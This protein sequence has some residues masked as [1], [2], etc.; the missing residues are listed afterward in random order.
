MREFE[1]KPVLLSPSSR[2]FPGGL[3]AALPDA[4]TCQITALGNLDILPSP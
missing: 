3:A 2:V 1:H 4:A